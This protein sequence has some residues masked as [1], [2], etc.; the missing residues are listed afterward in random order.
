[1]FFKMRSAYFVAAT[2][3]VLTVAAVASAK[4]KASSP[5]VVVHAKAPG[6]KIEGTS[7]NLVIDE[8]DKTV[9]FKTF[10]NSINTG[11]GMRNTHMQ[12][13]MDAKNHNDITL[14]VDKD[15]IDSKKGGTVQ[16]LLNFHGVK[17]SYPVNYTVKD[18]HVSGSFA[19]NVN[20]HGVGKEQLCAFHV[21]AEPGVTIDVAFDLAD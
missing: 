8:S 13:R 18:K 2:S 9:T 15:K 1:M 11:N 21:C 17:K 4:Y 10:L 7:S 12:E 3:C 14:T 19:F 6:M 5:K 20:D 16:G